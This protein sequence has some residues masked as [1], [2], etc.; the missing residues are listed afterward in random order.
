MK[1]EVKAD[2]SWFPVSRYPTLP[3]NKYQPNN[4]SF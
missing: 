1:T 2:E 3:Q 4:L